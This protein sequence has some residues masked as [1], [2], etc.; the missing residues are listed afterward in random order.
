M[1]ADIPALASMPRPPVPTH[2]TPRAHTHSHL[3]HNAYVSPS[4]AALQLRPVQTTWCAYCGRSTE[5]CGPVPCRASA[6]PVQC[7]AGPVPGQCHAGP[8]A[9][10]ASAMSASAMHTVAGPPSSGALARPSPT[11]PPARALPLPAK[12]SSAPQGAAPPRQALPLLPAPTSQEA[13]EQAMTQRVTA[14]SIVTAQREEQV[15]PDFSFPCACT[16]A[17]ASLATGLLAAQCGM[18]CENDPMND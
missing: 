16:H 13:E 10:S 14:E 12:P 7:H 9:M 5:P 11:G 1:L 8:F 4:T 17:S 2:P 6:M 15:M 18:P 3:T